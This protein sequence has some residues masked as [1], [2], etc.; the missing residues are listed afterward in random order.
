MFQRAMGEGV[1]TSCGR[2]LQRAPVGGCSNEFRSHTIGA[3]WRILQR[4]HVLFPPHRLLA[5]FLDPSSSLRSTDLAAGGVAAA[6]KDHMS[7]LEV[8]S[9]SP[10]RVEKARRLVLDR[11]IEMCRNVAYF[12]GADRDFYRYFQF[13]YHCRVRGAAS[14]SHDHQRDQEDSSSAPAH[15]EERSA[16]GVRT[17]RFTNTNVPGGK[18]VVVTN[19]V[20]KKDTLRQMTGAEAKNVVKSCRAALQ[21]FGLSFAL[22]WAMKTRGGAAFLQRHSLDVDPCL[23][24]RPP[25]EGHGIFVFRGDH[26]PPP[27]SG[28]T[29]ATRPAWIQSSSSGAVLL[30]K[31][32]TSKSDDECDRYEGDFHGGKRHGNGVYIS[33]R[34]GLRYDGQF[35][36]D[37]RHGQGILTVHQHRREVDTT[38]Q[39]Q[40]DP[41]RL[42]YCYDGEW[43]YDRRQGFGKAI[44]STEKYSGQWMANLFHGNGSWVSS[45]G[46]V[47][48]DGDF[49]HGRFHGLGKCV[50]TAPLGSSAPADPMETY[51]GEFRD[52]LRD[53]EGQLQRGDS[54]YIG[55]WSRG[56]KHGAGKILY[57]L[58]A[59]AVEATKR[60]NKETVEFEAAPAELGQRDSRSRSGGGVESVPISLEYDG[61]WADDRWEFWRSWFLIL[62]PTFW[63]KFGFLGSLDFAVVVW[64]A[65]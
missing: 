24:D 22:Q 3:R 46:L 13:S 40:E 49:A 39:T 11:V 18:L 59:S 16:A 52:G 58:D 19:L 65:I 14:S 64:L 7:L 12:A 15:P 34:I 17:L 60:R 37:L 63:K 50:L 4:V 54:L 42:V 43:A 26:Y 32:S 36:F 8:Q 47:V 29:G 9:T 62:V 61:L 5:A 23:R 20:V 51:I 35:Q 56:K 53:G 38:T 41:D 2:M 44:S 21:P 28:Q 57:N 10:A 55:A 31:N 33:P 25:R 45:D 30:S 48:Y 6:T 1:L 27:S